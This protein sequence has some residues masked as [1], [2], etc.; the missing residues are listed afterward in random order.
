MSV[1]VERPFVVE[2]HEDQG[3]IGVDM[4]IKNSVFGFTGRLFF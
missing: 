3:P 1:C 2:E 4:G